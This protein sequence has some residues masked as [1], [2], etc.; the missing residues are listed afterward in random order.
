MPRPKEGESVE[1]IALGEHVVTLPIAISEDSSTTTRWASQYIKSLDYGMMST[2]FSAIGIEHHDA[3]EA[4]IVAMSIKYRVLSKYTAWLAVDRSRTTDQVITQKLVQPQ[5]DYIDDLRLTSVLRHSSVSPMSV[6]LKLSG[7]MA[8]P[9]SSFHD[10]FL[11]PDVSE[12]MS[13]LRSIASMKQLPSSEFPNAVLALIAEIDQYLSAS[14]VDDR[15]QML[16]NVRTAS[17]VLLSTFSKRIIGKRLSAE[18]ETALQSV[19]LDV[20]SHTDQTNL[21]LSNLRDALSGHSSLKKTR[22]QRRR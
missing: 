20:N 6:G 9:A 22:T 14:P 21:I 11:N 10:H 8:R 2:D 5:I 12:A 7:S 19:M 16:S 18:L 13:K 1:V 3:L 15:D 4:Q 17:L